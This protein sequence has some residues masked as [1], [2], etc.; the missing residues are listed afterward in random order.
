MAPRKQASKPKTVPPDDTSYDT[1]WLDKYRDAYEGK[2]TTT[3][4]TVPST[5]TT[6]SGTS[7]TRTPAT[8]SPDVK[9]AEQKL[10]YTAQQ[11]Q[12]LGINTGDYYKPTT[13]RPTTQAGTTDT[14]WLDKYRDA[15]FGSG[16][17]TAQP[18]KGT[19]S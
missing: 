7:T 8:L 9:A 11:A 16:T 15:Y 3:T 1:S 13:V 18:K 14:S 17:Q 4:T 10:R 2:G 19:A 12:A 5:T 6:S